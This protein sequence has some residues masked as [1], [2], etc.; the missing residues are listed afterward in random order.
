[1]KDFLETFIDTWHKSSKS[2]V[3]WTLIL[4]ITLIIFGIYYPIIPFIVLSV[5]SL[6]CLAFWAQL[7]KE[8]DPVLWTFFMPITWVMIFVSL[9][10]VFVEWVYDKTVRPFNKFIN[11]L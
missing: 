9:L 2:E 4:L 5:G 7:N 10:I 11:N 3:L 8:G 6:L 1:M